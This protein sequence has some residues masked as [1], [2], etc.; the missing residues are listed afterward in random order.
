MENETEKP[1]RIP[2]QSRPA[3]DVGEIVEGIKVWCREQGPYF[4]T[5]LTAHLVLAISCMLILE[6]LGVGFVPTPKKEIELLSA[7]E[8]P[9][10]Q[11]L[12]HFDIGEPSVDPSELTTESLTAPPEAQAEVEAKSYDNNPVFI[13]AGGGVKA[14]G[15]ALGGLGGFDVMAKGP[16]SAVRGPGGVGGSD[17]FGKSAGSGGDGAG[18]GGRGQGQRAAMVGMFGGTKGT[19][20]AVAA[21]LLWLA[22][23]QNPDGSWSLKEFVRQCK[24]GSCGG[25]GS[26]NSDA[27]ATAFGLL[28]FLAAGQTHMGK[29]PYQQ[30]VQ[31]GLRWLVQN[32]KANGDLSGKNAGNGMMY[33]HGLATIALCEAYALT[34]ASDVRGPAQKAIDFLELAQDKTG[35]GWRYQPNEPGDTS[36][37]G[38]C[39]MACKS[40]LMAGLKVKPE[41]MN[42]AKKYLESCSK[43]K[44][45]Y[46][47]LY[48]Y[49]PN[50]GPTPA[51]T[52]VGLLCTQYMGARRED[53]GMVEGVSYLMGNMPDKGQRNIYYWYYATQVLH[54][55]LGPDWDSW[56]RAM[57][58]KLIETQVN[59]K[60]CANGSWDPDKPTKDQWGEA[61][62]R[63]MTTSLSCLTLEIYYR[64]LPLYKTNGND[65][66]E[67]A[68][69][70]D[71]K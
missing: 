56:N 17:G 52:S 24:G 41:T 7:V 23:H 57:R 54:N 9:P 26:H 33:T 10:Q 1:A 2:R 50:G 25:A 30:T 53:Q 43:G 22:K 12:E 68:K 8:E 39:I 64:Y 49:L 60:S 4:A 44:G 32:Q 6:L 46:G 45:K 59:D 62:G 36:V 37:A 71:A 11:M 34:E 61:G 29:G 27:A 18:Y 51:M 3:F 63:M 69:V 48:G 19:E 15:A 42:L 65:K 14:A 31:K 38:W 21:A 67:P 70:A 16:G 66:K 28:P 58:R 55:V 20:R 35:G 13:E 40:G 47:G 5:S